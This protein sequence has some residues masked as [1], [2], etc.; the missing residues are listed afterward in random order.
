M[1]SN[2]ATSVYDSFFPQIF[3]DVWEAWS[4]WPTLTLPKWWGRED[5]G[6]HLNVL[7]V[8]GDVGRVGGRPLSEEFWS[9]FWLD[10][11]GKR[12]RCCNL[13]RVQ[14]SAWHIILRSI[15]RWAEMW[16]VTLTLW[17]LVGYQCQVCA[18]KS[19]CLTL[20]TAGSTNACWADALSGLGGDWAGVLWS[21]VLGWGILN[22][23]KDS[24]P[25]LNTSW[26][27]FNAYYQSIV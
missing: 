2:S 9:A 23:W 4:F 22:S 21:S 11:M 18:D 16:R 25:G 6:W 17:F 7:V 14:G 3:R 1:T 12:R 27:G 15:I 26:C 8:P 19:L 10:V 24:D 5:P 20:R 13:A